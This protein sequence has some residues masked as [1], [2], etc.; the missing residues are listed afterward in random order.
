MML[1]LKCHRFQ[2]MAP[3]VMSKSLFLVNLVML[4]GLC[5][6]VIAQAQPLPE[7][8]KV[9]EKIYDCHIGS[10][11]EIA[12]FY[13]LNDYVLFAQAMRNK[14]RGGQSQLHFLVTTDM[15]Y[16]YLAEIRLL[17]GDVQEACLKLL[18]REVDY[19]LAAPLA[20]LLQRK[21]RHHFLFFENLPRN[22]HCSSEKKHCLSWSQWTEDS[23]DNY[24]LTAYRYSLKQK[25]NF[26]QRIRIRIGDKLIAPERGKLN[27]FARKQYAQRLRNAMAE[28]PADR[29]EAKIF[30]QQIVEQ[31]EHGLP[32]LILRQLPKQGWDLT[33]VDRQQGLAYTLMQRQQLELYPQTRQYY[34]HLS[35]Q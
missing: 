27:A 17:E 19:Q 15:A 31:A 22:N 9:P 6:L 12:E 24:L 30:Y 32:L 35:A 8:A 5:C 3:G 23:E 1:T 28:R 34:R 10:A 20:G 16:F 14:A 21:P 7:A 11:A 29:E 4:L 18:A 26:E 2:R 25:E 33:V 13:A